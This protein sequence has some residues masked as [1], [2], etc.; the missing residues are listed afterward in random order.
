MAIKDALINEL[1]PQDRTIYAVEEKIY[2]IDEAVL[3][4]IELGDHA[5]TAR[6]RSKRRVYLDI[7]DA[8]LDA[9][10][11]ITPATL[12]E[13]KAIRDAVIALD[14]LISANE[15]LSEVLQATNKIL[16]MAAGKV[17]VSA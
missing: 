8:A 7:R 3:E 1:T 17:S 15:S 5:S 12:P 14:K 16:S 10:Q 9:N 13:A 2:A 11:I 6:L 4:S